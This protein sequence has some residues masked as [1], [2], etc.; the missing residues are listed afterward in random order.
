MKAEICPVYNGTGKVRDE[1][2]DKRTCHGCSGTGWVTVP[3]DHLIYWPSEDDK[4]KIQ[5]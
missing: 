3:E 5:L 4:A 2:G 1:G